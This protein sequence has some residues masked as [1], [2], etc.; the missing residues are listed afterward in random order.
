MN[1]D[2]LVIRIVSEALGWNFLCNDETI[3][4][5]IN[6]MAESPFELNILQHLFT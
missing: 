1:Y 2:T 5:D 6:D 4:Y 3:S